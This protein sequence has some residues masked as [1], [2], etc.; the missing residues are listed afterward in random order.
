MAPSP[1][2]SRDCSGGLF[3]PAE[4]ID[5][6]VRKDPALVRRRAVRVDFVRLEQSPETLILN[7]FD[8][9]CLTAVRQQ[10]VSARPE[11]DVWTGAVEGVP[12]SSV[13]LVTTSRTLI[14][15]I[16]SPPD[17]YQIRLLRDDVHLVNQ[18]DPSKYPHDKQP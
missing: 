3:T 15:T 1:A 4:G 2:Q 18:V 12:N 16:I 17:S 7:L 10:G 5:I 14:G 13:T 6:E 11:S 9:V 8:D